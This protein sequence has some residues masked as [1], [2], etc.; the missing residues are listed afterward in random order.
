MKLFPSRLFAVL[1]TGTL[2]LAGCA[3]DNV[4]NGGSSAAKS[5][6]AAKAESA[7]KAEPAAKPVVTVNGVAVPG[8]YAETLIASYRAQGAP[9]DENLRENVRKDLI[10][11]QVLEQA[12]VKAGVDKRPDIQIKQ[13]VVRQTVLIQDYLQD[14]AKNN[15]PTDEEL[16][17]EYD[18]IK[19]RMASSKEY[20]VRHILLKTEPE[21]KAVITRLGKG[22]KFAELAKKSLDQG[23][24]SRGGDLGWADPSSF[25]PPFSEALVGLG[26]G[27]YTKTPVKTDFGYHVILLEDSRNMQAPSFDDIKVQLQ[28][29]L[30]NKKL[31]S[32]IEQ[33]EQAA[34]VK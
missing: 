34:E 12:A 29:S 17:K 19:A 2:A 15:P 33:L 5:A 14:W 7:A 8:D 1:A 3:G 6:P 9:D 13:D 16:K 25:V 26:K 10:R 4:A 28:Q 11:R 22:A 27:K 30:Q 24:R 21:A 20:H 31:Q 32:H 18:E 23:S